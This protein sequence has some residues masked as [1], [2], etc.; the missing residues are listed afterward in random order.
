MTSALKDYLNQDFV[1]KDTIYESSKDNIFCPICQ[2]IK[3]KPVMCMN[4][5]NTFC[6]SCIEKWNNY[7]NYCPNRCIY[8]DYKYGILIG[9]IVSKLKFKCKDCHEII[10]YE[11][12]E[13]HVLSKCD[14]IAIKYK[15]DKKAS[16][17]EG[18]FKR[19]IVNKR[20]NSKNKINQTN[21]K[22]KSHL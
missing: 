15:I 14:T 20:G 5:Q 2:D 21:L 9:N 11:N 8:P 19:V 12:M 6:R 7:K 1:I 17:N 18:I 3:I 10:N 16:A 22:S 13:K 4:C